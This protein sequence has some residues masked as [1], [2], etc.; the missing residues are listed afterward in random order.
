MYGF[1]VICIDSAAFGIFE[2]FFKLS[3]SYFVLL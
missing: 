3:L 1:I 2:N